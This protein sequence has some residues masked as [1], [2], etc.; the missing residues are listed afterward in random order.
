MEDAGAAE[1]GGK[2]GCAMNAIRLILDLHKHDGAD[3]VSKLPGLWERKLDDRW[4]F[5]VNGHMEPLPVPHDAGA[6]E[7][8]VLPGECYVE[9]N[10][11]PAATFSITCPGDGIFAAGSAANYHTFCAALETALL[12]PT[13]TSG[14]PPTAKP[15][16]APG[17]TGDAH[18]R[19]AHKQKGVD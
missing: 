7:M 8:R 9:Y 11:W 6:P 13:C 3:P 2:E 18:R 16:S 14:T 12:S 10:G 5:W 17:L 19:K 1:G 4:T 15:G